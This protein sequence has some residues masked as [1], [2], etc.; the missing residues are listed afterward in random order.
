MTCDG[1]VRYAVRYRLSA[2]V[3]IATRIKRQ[4]Q[5]SRRAASISISGKHQLMT[6]SFRLAFRALRRTPAFTIVATLA[7]GIAIGANA[8]IFGLVDALW[9]RPLG[10]SEAG[11]IVRIFS[12]T[13]ANALGAFS[14]PELQGIRETTRSLD[15]VAAR[16]R[17]GA[18]MTDAD[19]SPELLLVN[20]VTTNFFSTLGVTASHGRLFT[21]A[22]DA[23]LEAQPAIVLGYAFWQRRFGGDPS[24]VGR[25]VRIGRGDSIAVTVRGVLPE[26]FRDLDA[27]ADRDLWM[28]P[29]TWLRLSDRRE[30]E[31]RG[32]RWFELIGRLRQGVSATSAG[33]EVAGIA[34]AMAREFPGANAGRS[35]RVIS[36]FDYRLESAG[37]NA[38]ALL[39]L[40]LL[41]VLITCVNVANLLLARS[42]ARAKELAVKAAIG[43]GRG[44]LVRELLIESLLLG[45]AGAL[46]GITVGAWLIRLLPLLMIPPPGFRSSLVFHA[47]TRVL[48]FTAIV[49]LITTL[50]FGVAPSWMAAR[51]DLARVMRSDPSSRRPRTFLP[52]ALVTTQVAI[53]VVLLCA[54]A[55]LAVSF[56]DTRRADLG[57]T[58]NPLLTAWVTLADPPRA[59]TQN[60][61]R[62]LEQIGGVSRVA[63]AIR[64]PLSLSGGGRAQ[65]VAVP[66]ASMDRA[67]EVPDVKFN[68]VSANYFAIMGTRVIRGRGFSE[69]DE[70]PGEP[71]IVVSDRFARALFPGKDA[72]D[73]I[74]RLG[75]DGAPHR[76]VGIVQDAVINDIGE[77]G[78]PYFYL[79]YWRAEYGEAT[80]IVE[81]SSGEVTSIAAAVRDTL[82]H[83]DPRLE[84]RRLIA[85]S[86]YITYSAS[87]YRATAA[88]AASLGFIGLLLTTLGVYGVVAYRTAQR[89]REFG[90]R[91]A[92]GAARSQILRLVVREG[93]RVAAAGLAI[94]IPAA[95]VTTRLLSSLLFGTGPWNAPAFAAAA[96][97]VFGAVCSAAYVPA[98]RATRV[99]PSTALREG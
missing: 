35:A 64:A 83:L 15:E 30:F 27:A 34:A 91:L 78:E 79:P 13:E 1:K 69:A 92:L 32:Q 7:L 68:A 89:T 67:A 20:V 45:A 3:R 23:E 50:L 98:R 51:V 62:Q 8:A 73:A 75:P 39:G 48:L 31:D 4:Q 16:G 11:R 22:D 63:V 74:V 40:V 96:A 57:I 21:P 82:K 28:P 97:I 94:G 17:R 33:A 66:G 12:T 61:V 59:V 38:F 52:D 5:G 90:V 47:D 41:V 49:T 42:A 58:R 2:G 56:L 88:L 55:V 6:H 76:I 70:R 44:R 14:Y 37:V 36:D 85:M 71:V 72:L 10:V 18:T 81:S 46:A 53:S 19:G 99:S 25:T 65:R 9:L 77:P 26:T 95:L 87:V 43:A 54:A 86:D 80:Y 29:Q 93:A 24:V 84:P 60:A